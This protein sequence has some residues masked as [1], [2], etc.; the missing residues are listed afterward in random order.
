MKTQHSKDSTVS[1][2]S[3]NDSTAPI[4]LVGLGISLATA[5]ALGSAMCAVT[6]M[7]ETRSVTAQ[8]S[9]PVTT[10]PASTI[11]S[12]AHRHHE[13][14]SAA[15]PAPGH[16]HKA[17]P[18]HTEKPAGLNPKRKARWLAQMASSDP[19]VQR[20]GIYR[21][22]GARALTPE[23]GLEV[24]ALVK[25]SKDLAFKKTGVWAISRSGMEDAEGAL[26]ELALDDGAV[27]GR[28]IDALTTLRT[29]AAHEGMARLLKGS[30]DVQVRRRSAMMLGVVSK[31]ER[32]AVNV[33]AHSAQGDTDPAVRS[34][35]IRALGA[36]TSQTAMNAL[37]TLSETASTTADREAA[38]QRLARTQARLGTGEELKAAFSTPLDP[39]MATAKRHYTPEPD[40][41]GDEHE[42]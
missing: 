13:P 11:A 10:E 21:L 42:G 24:L 7:P 4:G 25:A 23:Q 8:V 22:A 29:P 5:L 27:G 32:S 9:A 40:H 16:T 39:R 14:K 26:T 34:A 3:K 6:Y 12:T 33:L 31:G 37:R 18:D 17:R 19:S 1:N 15:A 38:A 41:H 2:N 28:V 36:S 35:A 20:E 30:D